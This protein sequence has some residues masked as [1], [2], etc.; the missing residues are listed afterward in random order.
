MKQETGFI[1]FDGDIDIKA[2]LAM[3]SG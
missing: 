3:A 1:Q 2:I